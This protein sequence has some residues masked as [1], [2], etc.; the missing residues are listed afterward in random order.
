MNNLSH[1]DIAIDFTA[2][3]AI[4]LIYGL[5]PSKIHNHK[6]L[7]GADLSAYYKI[8]PSIQRMQHCYEE[9]REFYRNVLNPPEFWDEASPSI[10]LK[11]VELYRVTNYYDNTYENIIYAWLNDDDVSGFSVQRFDRIQITQWLSNIGIR[12]QYQFIN[13]TTIEQYNSTLRGESNDTL[14]LRKENTYLMIIG[15]ML[16]LIKSPRD[17]RNSDAAVIREL[18][19]NYNDKPGISQRNLESKFREAKEILLSS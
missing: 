1:W 9:T 14:S 2:E 11:S 13:D 17:G 7:K 18:V 19:D 16:E 8:T 10:I 12:S 3:Q 6:E 5:E 4:S 15:A